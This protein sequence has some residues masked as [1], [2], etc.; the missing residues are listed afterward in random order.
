M[1]AKEQR[2]VDAEKKKADLLEQKRADA[3]AKIQAKEAATA[4]AKLA[5]E[6]V[7]EAIEKMKLRNVRQQSYATV[8]K[9]VQDLQMLLA[10]LTGDQL[11]DDDAIEAKQKVDEGEDLLKSLAE[12]LHSGAGPEPDEVKEFI[13]SLK[14]FL[15]QVK[16]LA[17]KKTNKGWA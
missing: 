2:K 12:S 4:A 14:P 6:K 17:S 8:M 9:S 11:A 1:S 7:A 16:K 13:S 5:K 3:D 15:P 10:K